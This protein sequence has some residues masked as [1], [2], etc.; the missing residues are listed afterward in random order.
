[1]IKIGSHVT[2]ASPD[3]FLGSVRESLTYEANAMMIYTGPP[4]NNRRTPIDKLKITEAHQLMEETGIQKADVIVH[5]PYLINLANTLKE[6]TFTFSE[7]LLASEYER[8]KALGSC[9]MVLHPGSHLKEGAEKGI[10]SIVKGLNEVLKD[11][12]GVIIC[13]ETMAG[14]GSEV[15]RSF[16]EIAEIIAG[17]T[18]PE[19]LGVC[20]DTCHIHDAG[21][22]LSDPDAL[23]EEFDQVIGLNKLKVIHLND[24]LNARGAHKDRHANLGYGQI[25]FENL[26][27][28]AYHPALEEIVKILETPYVNNKAPYGREIAS[29]R[30]RQWDPALKE[31]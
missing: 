25:G 26:M 31:L 18:Y 23:L 30:K 20:L 21:Y 15:G 16:E 9:Y 12:E 17:C 14:K 13:L 7:E 8:T 1:M 24:S 3:Y 28:I 11:K 27:N 6:D 29:I 22:D 4:Q 2:F 19:K 10:S 5:A